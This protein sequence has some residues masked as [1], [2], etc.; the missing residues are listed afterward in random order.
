MI[1]TPDGPAGGAGPVH[2]GATD[3]HFVPVKQV[4]VWT[5]SDVMPTTEGI[6]DS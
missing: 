5:H 2:D 4:V 1:R 6:P 3:T